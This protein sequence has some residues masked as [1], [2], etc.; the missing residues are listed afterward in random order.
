MQDWHKYMKRMFNSKGTSM[1][2]E[3][4]V[5][6]DSSITEFLFFMGAGAVAGAL[7]ELLKK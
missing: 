3:F 6:A 1:F 4:L 5:A 2:I 7:Y